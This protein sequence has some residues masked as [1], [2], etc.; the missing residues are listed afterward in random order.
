MLNLAVS[1]S[2]AL[3]ERRAIG[4]GKVAAGF[5]AATLPARSSP[6]AWTA[7]QYKAALRCIACAPHHAVPQ[8]TMEQALGEKG[9]VALASLVQ[10][11]LLAL[12]PFSSPTWARDLPL[13]VYGEELEAVVTMP[14]PASLRHVLA[15]EEGW[16]AEEAQEAKKRAAPEAKTKREGEEAQG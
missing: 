11:N 6:P 3:R 5:R 14:S 8:S 7:Q 10:Y 4:R 15:L 16:A 13:E 12:R 2:A 1:F 9:D